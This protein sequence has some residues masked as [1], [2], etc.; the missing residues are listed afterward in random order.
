MSVV[1]HQHQT[2][3]LHR[4]THTG[5]GTNMR[6]RMEASF[7]LILTHCQ[8]HMSGQASMN[9]QYKDMYN[10]LHSTCNIVAIF[11]RSEYLNTAYQL[12]LYRCYYTTYGEITR[13]LSNHR[14][15]QTS[16][17]HFNAII[18]TNLIYLMMYDPTDYG[19]KLHPEFHPRYVLC[20]AD[21]RE[22]F[23]V[24][25][26]RIPIIKILMSSQWLT[27]GHV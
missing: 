9:L 12:P 6:Q 21:H 13:R 14:D 4:L 8:L 23:G 20:V 16:M 19:I 1:K 25:T 2:V 3:T 11:F 22:N 18:L 7:S 17:K 26:I 10:N 15:F 27:I 5:L 24:I